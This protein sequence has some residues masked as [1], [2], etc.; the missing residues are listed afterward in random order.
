VVASLVRMKPLCRILSEKTFY[1]GYKGSVVVFARSKLQFYT[2]FLEDPFFRCRHPLMLGT[3]YI[4]CSCIP[5]IIVKKFR[6]VKY[7]LYGILYDGPLG[8]LILRKMFCVV[9]VGYYY[10]RRL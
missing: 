10:I 2:L 6:D 1:P 4:F 9:S 7:M 3:V 5:Q 8:L